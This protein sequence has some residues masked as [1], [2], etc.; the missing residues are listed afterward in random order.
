MTPFD[1][2]SNEWVVNIWTF[3]A[4][5][6]ICIIFTVPVVIINYIYLCPAQSHIL[7]LIPEL[8]TSTCCNAP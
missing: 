8:L 7:K 1:T 5:W 4:V 3:A 2:G 6:G